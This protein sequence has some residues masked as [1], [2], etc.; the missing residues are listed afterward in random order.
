MTNARKVKSNNINNNDIMCAYS[1]KEFKR[2]MKIKTR[3]RR[4]QLFFWNIYILVME[5]KPALYVF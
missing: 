4:E 2:V 3:A 5:L 1:E